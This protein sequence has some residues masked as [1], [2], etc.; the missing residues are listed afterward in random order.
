LVFASAHG[1][2]AALRCETFRRR[3]AYPL[4]GRSDDRNPILQACFHGYE[5]YRGQSKSLTTKGT[6]FHEGNL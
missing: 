1:D 5:L 6:K 4:A 3:P 2:A